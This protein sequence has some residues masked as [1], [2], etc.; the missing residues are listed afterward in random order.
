MTIEFNWLQG[1][2]GDVPTYTA[3]NDRNLLTALFDEGILRGITVTP[4][5]P[6]RT[7]ILGVGQAVIVGDDV[8]NLGQ[9]YLATITAA[10]TV[11][12]PA[13]PG[14]GTRYDLV[15]LRVRDLAAGGTAG[16]DIVAD[17]VS[18]TV[19]GGVPATPNSFFPICTVQIS[20]GE[21]AVTAGMVTDI[22]TWSEPKQAV[23]TV[24]LWYGNAARVPYGWRLLT[25]AGAPNVIGTYSSYPDLAAMLGVTT[26]SITVADVR[27]RVPVAIDPSDASWDVLGETGGAKTVAITGAETGAHTHPIDHDHGSTMVKIDLSAIGGTTADEIG[28]Q[29][30][31][32]AGGLT[33]LVGKTSG[34]GKAYVDLPAI[35]ATSGANA[36]A[37]G[38]NNVQPYVG[39]HVLLRVL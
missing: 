3:K 21:T 5:S 33:V 38:H 34:S 32:G 16:N 39:L 28:Y 9:P 6:S 18:G 12:I 37:T 11:N 29:A 7:V 36:A 14:S 27:G 26:G 24:K 31:A 30:L 15:G 8:G 23:G 1:T 13:A 17:V 19:G 2:S 10:E 20:A 25:D 22:R 4:G 35:A